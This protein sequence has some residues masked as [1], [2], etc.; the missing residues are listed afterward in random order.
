MVAVNGFLRDIHQDGTFQKSV[1]DGFDDGHLH[2][3]SVG[4]DIDTVGL[5]GADVRHVGLAIAQPEII[6]RLSGVSDDGYQTFLVELFV[7]VDANRFHF[8]PI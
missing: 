4:I 7:D 8:C 1:G 3:L 5:V 6:S 2:V